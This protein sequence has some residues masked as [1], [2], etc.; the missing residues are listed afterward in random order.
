MELV[1]V[2]RRMAWVLPLP[3]IFFLLAVG[4]VRCEGPHDGAHTAGRFLTDKNAPEAA[5]ALAKAPPCRFE[6]HAVQCEASQGVFVG[7]RLAANDK[8]AALNARLE[9]I[10][11]K[12]GLEVMAIQPA[13][14]DPPQPPQDAEWGLPIQVAES[15]QQP[16]EKE[17]AGQEMIFAFLQT[18]AF[19][20]KMD[21]FVASELKGAGD[22][23]PPKQ[24][25]A[26]KNLRGRHPGESQEEH[27]LVD[28]EDDDED[29]EHLRQL[30]QEL[31]KSRME[32]KR[33]TAVHIDKL[34]VQ[35]F[36]AMPR[37][38]NL[39]DERPLGPSTSVSFSFYDTVVGPLGGLVELV[40]PSDYDSVG[41]P[42]SSGQQSV[43]LHPRFG[44]WHGY[45]GACHVTFPA[46]PEEGLNAIS[47]ARGSASPAVAADA[48]THAT[49][50][51]AKPTMLQFLSNDIA[52]NALILF[53]EESMPGAHVQPHSLGLWRDLPPSSSP[54]DEVA[55]RF[56][57][58]SFLLEYYS[59]MFVRLCSYPPP[60]A[61]P[62]AELGSYSAAPSADASAAKAQPLAP[63]A[64][65]FDAGSSQPAQTGDLVI[66]QTFQLLQSV[67]R[68]VID[69]DNRSY[70]TW[71]MIIAILSLT[72]LLVCCACG[73]GGAMGGQQIHRKATG[74]GSQANQGGGA[75]QQ[76]GAGAS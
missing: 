10:G 52:L 29:R 42:F 44:G 23:Q 74:P 62:S 19:Y 32:Y 31:N 30:R 20:D 41:F 39:A 76:G 59:D 57:W 16:A 4:S 67:D 60:S 34:L 48:K 65:A 18:P 58:P 47:S 15:G 37:S 3:T 36:K 68:R 63:A 6:P 43:S 17:T 55:V 46:V 49:T 22:L 26:Q 45:L 69:L 24:G 61:S 71:Q 70:S 72:C 64:S 2:C 21:A 12:L 33:M 38:W 27:Q 14:L 40:S 54:S 1:V 75:P 5:W 11:A 53:N 51:V 9:A 35:D 66:D 7:R 50:D 28:G 73:S 13:W 56:S 25:A 8:V